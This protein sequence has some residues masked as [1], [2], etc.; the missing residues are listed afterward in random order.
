MLVIALVFI[1]VVALFFLYK[2][3]L[4]NTR[5]ALLSKDCDSKITENSELK[6]KIF[7]LENHCNDLQKKLLEC[8]KENSRLETSLNN[9]QESAAERERFFA[10][11][12]EKLKLEFSELAQ[13]LLN[14]KGAQLQER[15]NEKLELLLRPFSEQM[16][17]FRQK[18][19]ENH[20]KD[21][22]SRAILKHEI[23][24]L[25]ASSIKISE[26]ALR[27]TQALRGD[28]KIQGNWGEMILERIL[29]DSALERG[30][31]YETQVSLK[32]DDGRILRPDVIVH[33]PENRDVIID[34]KVSLVAYE[35]YSQSGEESDMLAH[36][37]SL[38][39]HINGLSPKSYETLLR[40]RSLDFVLMF[41]PIEGAFIDALRYDYGLFSSAYDKNI[42]IVSP[43]TLLVT[44]RTIHNIWRYERQSQNAD[45]IARR[46]GAM[47]DKFVGFSDMFLKIGKH[48]EAAQKS[49]DDA[50]GKLKDGKGNLIRSAEGLRKLGVK[51]S[52]NIQEELI[53]GDDE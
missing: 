37:A 7:T 10:E 28:K 18:L 41:V 2:I 33:L 46:A 15:Q 27:L 44:L 52:K 4:L 42:I 19:E 35:R 9:K 53:S 49:Y 21:M 48:L 22:E 25:K 34:S 13:K 45:E 36:I 51:S 3:S 11:N 47:Y 5:V 40:G 38:K 39:A 24:N 1:A 20:A 30:R 14:E 17:G 50:L 29:E 23:D 31:E 26:D 12:Q 32:N 6:K 8:A 16:K 43:S